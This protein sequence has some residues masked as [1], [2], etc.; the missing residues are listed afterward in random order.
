MEEEQCQGHETAVAAPDAGKLN[1]PKSALSYLEIT[2]LRNHRSKHL[3]GGAV[4]SGSESGGVNT[5]ANTGE[6]N[7]YFCNNCNLFSACTRC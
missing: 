4:A 7:K 6:S 5:G 3:A 2:Q 1:N